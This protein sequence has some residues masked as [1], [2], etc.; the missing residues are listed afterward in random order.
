MTP[1]RWA[2]ITD[3]FGYA[4]ELPP[5]E[6]AAY[7]KGL[8]VDDQQSAREVVALIAAHERP[9]DFLPDL[10]A[11]PPIPDLSGRT[12]DRYR[13]MQLLGSGGMGTVYRAER[14]DGAFSKQ[15]AVKLLSP[16]FAHA[17]NRVHR[18]RDL[19]ARLDHPNIARLI[20]GGTTQEGWPYLVMDYVE[21]TAID[22]YCADRRLTLDDRLSL[23]IQVCAGIA[24]AHQRL[25]MHCDIKP[26]NVLVTADGTAKLLD[27]GI[28]KLIGG[29]GTTTMWRPGTPA[30]ASPEQLR[31]AA[32]TTA[33]DVY[34][35]GVLAYVVLSG[36]WPYP[37]RPHGLAD[38]VQSVLSDDPVAA[39][40]LLDAPA[41]RARSLRDLDNV[42]V[43]AVAKD[44][45][46]RYAS[47][48][49]FAEDL[50]ACRRGFPVRARPDSIAYRLSRFVG[51]HRVGSAAA[52]LGVMAIVAA[53]AISWR[54]ARTAQRRHEDL[55][56]FAHSVVVDVNN[57]LAGVAGTTASRKMLVDTA[58]QYLERL[59][60]EGRADP[61]LREDLASAYI[62]IAKV[63]GG[64]FL[65][66]LGDTSGAIRSLQKALASIGPSA[67]GPAIERLRMEAHINVAQL[68][69][70]P[71]DGAPDFDRA[72]AVGESYLAS[73]GGD[74]ASVR[75]VAQAYHGKATI[76]HLTDNVPDHERFAIRAVELR[77][78]VMTLAPDS[79]Q[80]EIALARE[81]AQH[82]LALTQKSDP[83]AALARLN[84]ARRLLE[85]TN[86]RVPS[87]QLIVRG[88]AEIHSRST[89]V[90]MSLGKLAEAVGEAQR[91][92][93]LLT[94][95]V[96]SDPLNAQYQSDLATAWLRQSEAHRAAGHLDIALA[97]SRRALAVR[98]VQSAKNGSMFGPWGLATNLN[99]VGTLLMARSSRNWA[100]AR[101]LFSDARDIAGRTLAVAPSF[102]EIRKELAISYA[103]LADTSA[104]EHGS[105]AADVRQLLERSA[106][107]WRD[108]FAH[109]V[110]DHRERD[111]RERVEK[112]LASLLPDTSA[113]DGRIVPGR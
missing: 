12:L 77:E 73:N 93:D 89:F 46:R 108:V 9:G 78:R 79:W 76:A 10:P 100:E 61:S 64:A 43:K 21:G 70:S 47:V 15:V 69:A 113:A 74:V 67:A 75:L 35:I 30:F 42:L 81:Y 57:S 103:G 40:R 13:L 32:V 88:L 39:S 55:R 14:I 63:Q 53:V 80:D 104:A 45:N 2:Q 62:Q 112:R 101:T 56:Q 107:T 49:Q 97:L 25:V 72:I 90:L 87:N 24:H 82:A 59:G 60:N 8:E 23:L 28:A 106:E 111:R 85:A 98:R 109:G 110:G 7:L 37:R 38:A 44:P 11:A 17:R 20:D 50:D 3:L 84:H 19:L 33:S 41:L 54:E 29:S 58:L 1:A 31:G 51:R 105:D 34:S 48:E 16:V 92:I 96:V 94:P 86:A 36:Q 99:V 68:A 102:N 71:I 6:R 22:R 83:A 52:A 66:N 95:L 91:A 18:E 27:F 65:P 4:L 5:A 26:E